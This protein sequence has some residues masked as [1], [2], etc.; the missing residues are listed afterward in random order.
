MIPP[1]DDCMLRMAEKLATLLESGGGTSSHRYA[2][3]LGFL[4]LCLEKSSRDGTPP[5]GVNTRELAAKMVDLYFPQ[6]ATF[7]G[8]VLRQS[9]TGQAKLVSLVAAFR[10]KHAPEVKV[11]LF[12]AARLAPRAYERLLREVEWQLVRFL[13]PKLQRVGSEPDEFLFTLGWDESVSREELSASNFDHQ[14]HFKPGVA[15]H[16][17]ALSRMLRPLLHQHWARFVSQLNELREPE[18]GRFLFGCNRG[19]LVDVAPSLYDL[20]RGSCFYCGVG[21][22][23]GLDVDHFLPWWRHPDDGL[24]NLV[25]AHERCIAQKAEFLADSGHVERWAEHIAR[26]REQLALIALELDWRRDAARS[27]ASLRSVYMQLPDDA[28]LWH[29]KGELVPLDRELLTDALLI[30]SGP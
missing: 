28:L 29:I 27:V 22:R 2:L 5:D 7:E 1:S 8:R 20:Q 23:G 21:M 10:A 17:V 12:R 11:G 15:R 18:L 9:I 14:V 30:A 26:H 3:L 19:L 4:D 6:T 13:L 16:L 25:A 24:D